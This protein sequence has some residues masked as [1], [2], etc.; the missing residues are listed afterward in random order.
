MILMKPS[1]Y[2]EVSGLTRDDI[3]WDATSNISFPDA[4]VAHAIYARA[5][6]NTSGLCRGQGTCGFGACKFP[7]DG[8]EYI[9]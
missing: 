4:P 9:L 8:H 6:F 1:D 5:A 3:Y 2:I 7:L